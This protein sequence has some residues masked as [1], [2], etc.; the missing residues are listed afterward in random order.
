M[1]LDSDAAYL[2]AVDA[3]EEQIEAIKSDLAALRLSSEAVSSE[4][5]ISLSLEDIEAGWDEAKRFTDIVA[6]T[7]PDLAE[8][9]SKAYL[10]LL[11]GWY[12]AGRLLSRSEV[13][14][15]RFGPKAHAAARAAK[16]HKNAPIWQAEA[17]LISSELGKLRSKLPDITPHAAA[18]KIYDAVNE[19]LKRT[20]IAGRPSKLLT[21]PTIAR[22]ILDFSL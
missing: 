4:V 21:I 10:R 16:A 2:K 12:G 15:R 17:E 11:E 5:E 7:T 14:S 1:T 19:R 3:I 9:I 8:E 18:P 20:P 6:K 22:R 13:V